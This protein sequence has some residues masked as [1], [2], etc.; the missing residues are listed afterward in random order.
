MKYSKSGINFDT[1]FTKSKEKLNKSRVSSPLVKRQRM[2]N[3][4]KK[5]LKDSETKDYLK[6]QTRKFRNFEEKNLTK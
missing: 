2:K 5:R 4:D 6:K 3:Y 1:S